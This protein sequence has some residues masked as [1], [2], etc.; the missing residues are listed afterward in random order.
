MFFISTSNVTMFEQEVPLNVAQ[1]I[2]IKI[3]PQ[4]GVKPAEIL[5]RLT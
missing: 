2:I 1:G 5:K 3:L 4:E